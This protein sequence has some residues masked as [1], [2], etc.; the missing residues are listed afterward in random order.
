MSSLFNSAITLF[1][2]FN[3]DSCKNDAGVPYTYFEDVN[4][5]VSKMMVNQSYQ[6]DCILNN[7]KT[8][9]RICSLK[10]DFGYTEDEIVASENLKLEQVRY[11]IKDCPERIDL[12][13]KEKTQICDLKLE[14]LS[15]KTIANVLKTPD[16][17]FPKIEAHYNTCPTLPPTTQPPLPSTVETKIC[18]LKAIMSVEEVIEFYSE[19]PKEQVKAAYQSCSWESI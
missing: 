18:K 17:L 5:T 4:A 2:K 8:K 10:N 16:S 13:N 11:F 6:A 7:N 9:R 12:T 1:K 19:Y 3:S 14:G 15:V